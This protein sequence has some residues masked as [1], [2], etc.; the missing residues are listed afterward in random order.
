MYDW[1][2]FSNEQEEKLI[3]ILNWFKYNFGDIDET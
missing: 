2:R 1:E 3:K